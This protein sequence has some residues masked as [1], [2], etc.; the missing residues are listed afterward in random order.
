M[1][2]CVFLHVVREG[3]GGG[4]GGGGEGEGVKSC[5]CCGKLWAALLCVQAWLQ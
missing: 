2:L 3:A 5:E 1:C 4:G